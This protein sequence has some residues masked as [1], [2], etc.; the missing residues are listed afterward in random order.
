MNLV[1][2]VW[3]NWTQILNRGGVIAKWVMPILSNTYSVT[4]ALPY[5]NFITDVICSRMRDGMPLWQAVASSGRDFKDLAWDNYILRM[6]GQETVISTMDGIWT[7]YWARDLE[8]GAKELFLY[9]KSDFYTP[10]RYLE[11]NVIPVRR[12]LA[13]DVT[14]RRW[15]KSPHVGHLRAHTKDYTEEIKRFL[16]A[17]QFIQM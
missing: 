11:E 17:I 6:K 12:K 2:W 5:S 10:Y 15:D 16:A 9:S 1:S 7:G 13:E 8:L 14:V 4:A 3:M